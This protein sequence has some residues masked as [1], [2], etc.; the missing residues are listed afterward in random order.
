MRSHAI[1][2]VGLG[3]ARPPWWTATLYALA[4]KAVF[5][6]HAGVR[7]RRTRPPCV[8]V[9][10][11]AARALRVRAAP[12]ASR[13]GQATSGRHPPRARGRTL[14]ARASSILEAARELH[15]SDLAMRIGVSRRRAT[16]YARRAGAS[17]VNGRAFLPAP[18]SA[19]AGVY[20]EGA[21]GA[22]AP[23]PAAVAAPPVGT[24]LPAPPPLP[25]GAPMP[26]GCHPSPYDGMPVP[27]F[28]SDAARLAEAEAERR[29]LEAAAEG[30][31]RR[32]LALAAGAVLLAVAEGHGLAALD[33]VA[34]EYSNRWVLQVYGICQCAACARL[35]K[36]A[37]LSPAWRPPAPGAILVRLA[38][39]AD[40]LLAR[41]GDPRLRVLS[42]GLWHRAG[43]AALVAAQAEEARALAEARAIAQTLATRLAL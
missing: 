25:A 22:P 28:A 29:E 13:G 39:T 26:A 40:D 27:D 35:G 8:S 14:T 38:Q 19:G 18:P 20:A 9:L 7:R 37:A 5:V 34:T 21:A 6:R 41:W 33:A 31:H 17:I 2:L 3:S 16:E 42:K 24:P 10:A 11:S 43:R 30:E 23:P 4:R 36:F 15:L 1:G 12:S 32:W